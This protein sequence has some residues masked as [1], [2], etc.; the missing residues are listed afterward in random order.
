MIGWLAGHW[1]GP[2]EKIFIFTKKTILPFYY[3]KFPKLK[4]KHF[5]NHF[6]P[7]FTN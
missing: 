5:L 3:R 2:I 7:F 4:N 1:I 6:Y